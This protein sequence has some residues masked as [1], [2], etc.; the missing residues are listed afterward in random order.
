M[1]LSVFLLPL[2]GAHVGAATIWEIC[3]QGITLELC[4]KLYCTVVYCTVGYSIVPNTK[5]TRRTH[6]DVRFSR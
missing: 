4:V 1:A 5:K 2:A 3:R 6:T